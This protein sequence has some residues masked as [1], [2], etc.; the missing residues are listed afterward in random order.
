[1]RNLYGV[2]VATGVKSLWGSA[3]SD[4]SLFFGAPRLGVDPNGPRILGTNLDLVLE[5]R[6]SFGRQTLAPF[7]HVGTGPRATHSRALTVT[8]AGS[9]FAESWGDSSPLSIDPVT[10]DRT[11][12]LSDAPYVEQWASDTT[13]GRLFA[14]GAGG[15]I[16]S[17]DP[18][19]G[20]ETLLTFPGVR[21][22]GPPA[23]ALEPLAYDPSRDVLWQHLSVGTGFVIVDVASG[24]RVFASR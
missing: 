8:S 17:F 9:V 10:G 7:Q 21:G 2:D 12:V 11:T 19:T 16:H 1:M 14:L 22:S 15:N 20:V 18:V 3:P 5:L 6:S 4:T 23:A 13:G 24:D